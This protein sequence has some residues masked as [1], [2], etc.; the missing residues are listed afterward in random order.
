MD[1][2]FP[3]PISILMPICNE[4]D[5]LDSLIDEWHRDVMQYLPSGSEMLFDDG[6]S[7]DGTL[8]KLDKFQQTHPYI[9]VLRSKKEGFAPAARRLYQ[10][11]RC[12]YVF[13][14]DSDGQYVPSEFWKIVEGLKGYDIAHGAKVSR[15]DPMIRLVGSF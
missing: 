3:H 15:K 14:T 12:P 1:R 9:R 10:E 7:T 2:S 11:A 13:F 6:A 4:V 5:V 8:E